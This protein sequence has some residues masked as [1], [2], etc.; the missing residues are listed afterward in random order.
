MQGLLNAS[1]LPKTSRQVGHEMV[2]TWEYYLAMFTLNEK[3]QT[4]MKSFIYCTCLNLLHSL[5]Y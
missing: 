5:F 4:F 1:G 3:Y 2:L